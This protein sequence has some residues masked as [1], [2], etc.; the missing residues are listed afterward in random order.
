MRPC[1]IFL[2][3]ATQLS[4]RL[5]PELQLRISGEA[6]AKSMLRSWSPAFT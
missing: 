4:L 1:Q 5:V 6:F 2:L 3:E